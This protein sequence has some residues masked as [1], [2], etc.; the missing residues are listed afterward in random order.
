MYQ[1]YT[2]LYQNSVLQ[3][4]N[5]KILIIRQNPPVKDLLLYTTLVDYY[6]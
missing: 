1:N 2:I 6:S 5:I 4:S 3:V